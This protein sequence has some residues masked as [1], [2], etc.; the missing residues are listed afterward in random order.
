MNISIFV[1]GLSRR[2]SP[3]ASQASRR[4]R[5]HSSPCDVPLSKISPPVNFAASWS[6]TIWATYFST[7]L[8]CTLGCSPIGRIET[9]G[10]S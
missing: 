2:N 3:T 6:R 5:A 4:M 8:S 9:S 10:P 7:L 1:A